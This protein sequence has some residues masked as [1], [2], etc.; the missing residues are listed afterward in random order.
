MC[1]RHMEL[2]VLVCCL[3]RVRKRTIYESLENHGRVS[4]TP[5]ELSSLRHFSIKKFLALKNV[6]ASNLRH[7]RR[8]IF[9]NE[10][11]LIYGRNR[12]GH[13]INVL[14][15]IAVIIIS[16][17]KHKGCYKQR[18]YTTRLTCSNALGSPQTQALVFLNHTDPLDS[19]YNHYVFSLL[20][21]SQYTVIRFIF[22]VKIF[23]YTENI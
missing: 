13:I 8:N 5:A 16:D 15:S 14:T 18:K 6:R 17:N 10:N 7:C 1:K 22:V 3:S 4:C 21:H 19:A 11:F 23:S 2:N 20:E 12:C 9:N